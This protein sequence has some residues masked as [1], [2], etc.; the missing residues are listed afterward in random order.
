LFER[1]C[2]YN[3]SFNLTI[4]LELVFV[5]QLLEN[6]A[7]PEDCLKGKPLSGHSTPCAPRYFSTHETK[8]TFFA[9]KMRKRTRNGEV[10]TLIPAVYI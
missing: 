2:D 8:S 9:Q 3:G 5:P 4:T 1:N 6:S 7:P 10:V